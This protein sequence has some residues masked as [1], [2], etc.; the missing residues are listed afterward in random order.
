MRHSWPED[1]QF[2]RVVLE[3]E[4]NVCTV[5]GAALHICDHRRHR[6]FTLQ[7]PVEVVCKLAHCSDRQCAAHAKTRSPYAETALTLPGWLIG[8]DVFCWVGHRR[9]A[10]HWS[11]PQIRS[12]LAD[13]YQIPLSADAIEDAVRRYQTML[14]ARQQDPQVVA[15]AYRNVAALVLSIDGLQ[16]EKGHETLYVVRELNAKRI[17]F[18]EALL[19]S[20]ADEVR[21][22]LIQAR[23]WATRL[24]LPVH[25]WLS[26]K[27]D[28]FVTGIAAEFPGVPHRYCVNHFLRDLAKPMLEADSHAK[29]T[30]RRKVRGLRA[31]EREVLQQRRRIA[32]ETPAVAPAPT[33]P[34]P[35][36]P[37]NQLAKAVP[38]A[39][40]PP[41]DAG[42]VV[43]DYCSAVRGILNDDQGGP[44]QPPGLRMAEAL[45]D[46]RASLQRNLDANRNGR[47]HTQLQRLAACIDRGV[48]DV[49]AEHQVIRQYLQE[50]Q[51]V[52]ATLTS[53][54]GAAT[55]RQA[56]CTRL[57]EEFAGLATSFYQHMAG[58]M[59]SF[60]AGLF[61]GGDT[62]PFLQDN[63][64]LER[65]FR[66]PKGH[67]R[68]IHGHRHAG[69][70]IVQEGP[71]LL[72]ALDAHGTHPEPFTAHDLEP[73][74]DTSAPPCQVN[75]LHRRKIM[76]KAR[77]KKNERSCSQTWNA[78]T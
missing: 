21:R 10:R 69:V 18:A 20:S 70:R 48:A 32:G 13:T 2:T 15:A 50:L 14:A 66:K 26:D 17:W 57:Q 61:V 30:M 54:N 45:G 11:V 24:G 59:A 51:R 67:E 62:R 60:A 53:A 31:I 22:L 27:Q 3:V 37:A 71:T 41:A 75:A 5:C 47:A 63:L 29:V 55:T 36:P 56:Q 68:R 49:Q 76:R 9:F 43:L 65:W 23:A 42:E 8:W 19:S 7:G 4:D 35:P 52:A 28:A 73:Y 44:F 12:E 74:Q 46:V 78:S 58:V 38:V 6:I 16:P 77:A 64:E 25:L 39:A 33:P 1:T 40:D 34:A 72:P